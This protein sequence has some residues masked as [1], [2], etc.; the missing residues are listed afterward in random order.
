MRRVSLLSSISHLL[1]FYPKAQPVPDLDD[2]C[3]L[4][5]QELVLYIYTRQAHLIITMPAERLAPTDAKPSAT[6]VMIINLTW[7]SQRIPDYQKF[8]LNFGD[9]VR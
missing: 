6:V 8:V 9:P 1:Q 3:V 2:V 4:T 7:I 5:V